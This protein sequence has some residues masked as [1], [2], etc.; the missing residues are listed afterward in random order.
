MKLKPV[1]FGFAAGSAACILHLG[2]A[3][4]F[5]LFPLPALQISAHI[6]FFK[7]LALMYPYL[8]VSALILASGLIQ[9]FVGTF[10]VAWLMAIIYNLGINQD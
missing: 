2:R 3:V 7:S 5:Y 8:R 4:L 6:F 9:I 10:L 1:R